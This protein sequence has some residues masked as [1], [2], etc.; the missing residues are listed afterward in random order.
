MH[1][2]SCKTGMSKLIV[3]ALTPA[4][5]CVTDSARSREPN[6]GLGVFGFHPTLNDRLARF[7]CSLPF[8]RTLVRFMN[9]PGQ[10]LLR[11]ADNNT[12]SAVSQHERFFPSVYQHGRTPIV[13]EFT[14]D[15]IELCFRLQINRHWQSA[16][17]GKKGCRSRSGHLDLI[18]EKEDDALF[19]HADPKSR[20]WS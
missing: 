7:P 13:W 2:K 18:I 10:C 12:N 15:G 3:L 8:G 5:R 11:G 14:I 20:V 9:E 16:M 6:S 19:E 4:T 1:R 17:K